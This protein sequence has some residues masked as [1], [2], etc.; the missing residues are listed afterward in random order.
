VLF[1]KKKI[2]FMKENS[3]RWGK[4]FLTKN[5]IHHRIRTGCYISAL[6]LSFTLSG[7]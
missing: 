4:I 2:V 5:E 1:V 7:Y 3:Q 6:Q